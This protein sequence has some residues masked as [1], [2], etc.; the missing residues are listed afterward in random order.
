MRSPGWG[1]IPHAPVPPGAQ[2]A[3]R[4]FVCHPTRLN[5]GRVFFT[6]PDMLDQYLLVDYLVHKRVV[7]S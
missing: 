4:S 2:G 5:R 3:P 7:I 1:L 6:G